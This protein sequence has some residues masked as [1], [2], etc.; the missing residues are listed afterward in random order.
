MKSRSPSL[1]SLFFI[2]LVIAIAVNALL[3][4]LFPN[5]THPVI[6]ALLAPRQ[7][8][9][10][11]RLPQPVPPAPAEPV[12]TLPAGA[13]T[14]FSDDFSGTAID[15]TKWKISGNSV[16][17]NDQTMEV[18][19][20]VTNAGGVLESVPFAIKDDGL[21]VITRQV[22]MH[23]NFGFDYDG[24]FG[25]TIGS[26]A[27]AVRYVTMQYSSIPNHKFCFGFFLTRDDARPNLESDSNNVSYPFLPELDKWFSEKVTY[28]PKT[29]FMEYFINGNKKQTF[30]VG[31]LEQNGPLPMTVLFTAGGLN[32]GHEQ[33]FKNLKVVQI[34][35]AN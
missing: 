12:A 16:V 4:Y 8:T 18:M 31:A 29:G 11:T 6:V 13:N 22:F 21:I 5:V 10:L 34:P 19:T 7:D 2:F 1:I 17:Q 9:T 14:V 30:N 33:V 23:Y 3:K 24:E 15:A 25:I 20:T 26:S 27:F 28:D 35:S 32:T